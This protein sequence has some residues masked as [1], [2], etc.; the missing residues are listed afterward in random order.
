MNIY[1]IIEKADDICSICT[2]NYD[3]SSADKSSADKSSA[4]AQI[5]SCQHIFHED[6]LNA[7]FEYNISCPMCRLQLGDAP[8][9][10]IYQYILL[11]LSLQQQSQPLQT[12]TDGL[13]H[14]A[15]AAV[16]INVLLE[17]YKTAQEYNS[18]RNIIFM[19]RDSICIDGYK[20]PS[21]L[22]LINR[23]SATRELKYRMDLLR[24][25]LLQ[26]LWSATDPYH[27][28]DPPQLAY[29][30]KIFEHPYLLEWKR[31]IETIIGN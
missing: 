31:K 26:H 27:L 8:R 2:D 30:K 13:S 1:N 28:S 23:T 18:M 10:N 20:L 21:T 29:G 16:F 3:T 11:L 5:K 22:N 15:F 24:S 25:Q 12:P 19:T 6:C 9:I 14:T 4:I 17:R 7:W